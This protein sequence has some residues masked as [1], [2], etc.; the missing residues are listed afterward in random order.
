MIFLFSFFSKI[1]G[2]PLPLIFMIDHSERCGCC[3]TFVI[4]HL[5]SLTLLKASRAHVQT[6]IPLPLLFDD[7]KKKRESASS[8]CEVLQASAPFGFAARHLITGQ[9]SSLELHGAFYFALLIN[10]PGASQFLRCR[11]RRLYLSRGYRVA[12]ICVID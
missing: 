3:N 9:T 12:R 8:L 6:L 1:D 10:K 7:K 5:V 4:L 2:E 11:F